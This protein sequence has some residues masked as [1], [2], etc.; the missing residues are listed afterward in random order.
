MR[1]Q[2][3]VTNLTDSN[4]FFYSNPLNG[5][6]VVNDGHNE[7]AASNLYGMAGTELL[8]N[9]T[10][11]GYVYVVVPQNHIWPEKTLIYKYVN[12]FTSYNDIVVPFK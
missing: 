11:T 12:S 3:R 5:A 1:I 10:K 6:V 4:T 9:E 7:F 2:L 8:W